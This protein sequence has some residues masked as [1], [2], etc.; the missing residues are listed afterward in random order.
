MTWGLGAQTREFAQTDKTT[1]WGLLT[2][3]PIISCPHAVLFD[4][5]VVVVVVTLGVSL[6]VLLLGFLY[7]IQVGRVSNLAIESRSLII[8]CKC[9][10]DM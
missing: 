8:M 1:M 2:L 10:I 4:V 7:Y 5:V 9:I 3:A 6:P